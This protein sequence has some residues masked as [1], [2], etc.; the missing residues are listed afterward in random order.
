MTVVTG[1]CLCG[2]VKFEYRGEVGPAK[3]C[4]CEDCRRCTGS[5]FNISVRIEEASFTLVKGALKGYAKIADSGNEL[6]RYF[7]PNCGSPVYTA[8]PVHEGIIYVKAGVFDDA[9]LIAPQGQSWVE[10]AVSW[11]IPPESN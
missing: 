9:S 6:T 11:R 1:A 3:F 2:H 8:S 7:C 4:H 10:S 5:A